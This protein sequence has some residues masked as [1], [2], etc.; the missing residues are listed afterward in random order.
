MIL[1]VSL[2]PAC[3]ESVDDRAARQAEEY[4][5]RNCPTPT[6]NFSRTDSVVYDRAARS[7]VYYCTFTGRFDNAEKVA[8]YRER[9]TEGLHNEIAAKV[10]MRP[11]VE[12][13]FSFVY[14]VRSESRPDVVL[15][16]D[17]IRVER[18]GR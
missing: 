15:Y 18:N 16:R 3:R 13:G 2:L 1:L 12:A 14:V 8:Q 11:Y 5:R 4:T 10:T 9:I 17:T 7:F 6:V